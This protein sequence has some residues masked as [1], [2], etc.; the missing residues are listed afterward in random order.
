MRRG[1]N[2]PQRGC[3]YMIRRLAPCLLVLLAGPALADA[4]RPQLRLTVEP[5]VAELVRSSEPTVRWAL[6]SEP[7]PGLIGRSIV[8]PLRRDYDE[9]GAK[10]QTLSLALGQTRFV[11]IRA[12][13]A[14]RERS[15]TGEPIG[16][17]HAGALGQ[18][19][20]E[21]GAMIGAG[22]E[23]RVG[24]FDLSARAMHGTIKGDELDPTMGAEVDRTSTSKSVT[25]SARLR[26]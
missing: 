22:V 21:G 25:A 6:P 26:F 20:L 8:P 24:R 4:K 18:R 14:P 1:T 23:R 3:Q 15:G 7:P 10:R 2:S 5:A 9:R 11:A 13:L 12:K 19:R 17:G 16:P